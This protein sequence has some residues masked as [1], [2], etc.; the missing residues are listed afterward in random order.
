MCVCARLTLIKASKVPNIMHF[1]EIQ[2]T[3]PPLNILFSLMSPLVSVPH[4]TPSC[5]SL[6]LPFIFQAPSNLFSSSL[7]HLK[8]ILQLDTSD[9]RGTLLTTN[10]IFPPPTPLS[11]SL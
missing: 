1:Q 9:H 6:A 2:V 3:S 10:A 5:A 4:F 8:Q 11:S 7:P